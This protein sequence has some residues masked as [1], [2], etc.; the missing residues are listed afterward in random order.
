MRLKWISVKENPPMNNQ[1]IKIKSD[2]FWEGEAIFQDNK[3]VYYYGKGCCFGDLTHW[4]TLP[5]ATEE[6]YG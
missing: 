3:C 5:T 2:N 4:K 1:K 6:Q